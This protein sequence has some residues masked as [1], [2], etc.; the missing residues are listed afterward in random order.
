MRVPAGMAMTGAGVG[1]VLL[2]AAP[3]GAQPGG[4]GGTT[5]TAFPDAAATTYTQTETTYTTE[6]TGTTTYQTTT[7]TKTAEPTKT[8]PTKTAPTKTRHHDGDKDRHGRDDGKKD[9]EATTTRAAP[10]KAQP[11]VQ[12]QHAPV[13]RSAPTAAQRTPRPIPAA[14]SAGTNDAADWQL[15]VGGALIVAGAA[16]V[17]VG[18]GRQRSSGRD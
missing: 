7:P 13:P 16:S 15:P 2:S 18:M 8:A 14:V 17:A 6:P 5:T 1:L 3:A 12:Q 11:T 10:T 9:H 4:Y